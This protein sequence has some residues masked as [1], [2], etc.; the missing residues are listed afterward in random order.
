[1]KLF[2]IG[3][4]ISQ[5]FMS[6]AAARTDLCFSTIISKLLKIPDYNVPEWLKGGLPVNIEAVF[7][8]LEKRLGANIQGPFEW[9]VALN[10]INNYLDDV[11]D[12]YESG[13]GWAELF[14]GNCYHNVSVR[15]FD[16]AYSW[17]L[18]P[19]TC[20]DVIETSSAS[21]D[22][23]WGI[24]NESLLRTALKVLETGAA[25][26]IQNPSQ[27]DWLRYHHQNEG[28][29]NVILWLGSNNAL[30]TVLDLNINQTSLDGSAFKDGPEKVDFLT[31]TE[32]G[33][34]L[35]HPGDFRKEY[36][37]LI[38]QVVSIMHENPSKIDY[39]IY[40]GTIP[41]V[42][43]LPIIKAVGASQDRESI[44]VIEWPVDIANPAPLGI[45]ELPN[46]FTKNAYSYAKYYAYFAFAENF[47][48]T[49]PHLNLVQ[50]LHID[51]TIRQYNRVIQE[52][53]AEANKKIGQRRFYLVDIGDA[54]SQMALKRNNYNPTYV[55]PEFFDF[56]YPKVDTRYYGTNRKGQIMA[57][58]L[59]SLDG[60]HPS[61]IGQGL[62]AHEFIK[63]M[64]KAESRS[65]ADELKIDWKQIFANDQLYGE[66][67]KL[68]TEI[69]D[70]A[71]FKK[72]LFKMIS[73]A[74]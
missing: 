46:R 69:Y 24:A 8:K 34:N 7:R 3:D 17:L 38:E 29:E 20:R 16:V 35:W 44:D 31:R 37:Y 59:F 54:L 32:K 70:N 33:W 53:I 45:G 27:L 10:I 40:V 63:V 25:G 11:E 74:I 28:V 48:I 42:T 2:T 30:G 21:G 66:P 57:G 5:G 43:I 18:S 50:I 65:P 73:T 51:N 52:I 4:S 49:D 61:A 14:K 41:L 60:V 56:I 72:W 64:N 19:K 9:P 15:G 23:W 1:M 47:Q 68:I 39:K 13:E 36:A 22:D 62:I 58:G 67:I 71:E 26:K 55:Y 12:Y 6:G